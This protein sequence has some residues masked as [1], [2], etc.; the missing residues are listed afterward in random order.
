MRANVFL[1]QWPIQVER[2]LWDPN[3]IKLIPCCEVP[4]AGT[5][6]PCCK[7]EAPY[8]VKFVG[9]NGCG[10]GGP[11]CT[12]EEAIE[13]GLEMGGIENAPVDGWIQTLDRHGQ[14]IFIP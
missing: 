10:C 6:F 3:L 11:F 12:E 5:S 4:D 9:P 14:T 8:Y 7:P 2:Q 1:E 13:F